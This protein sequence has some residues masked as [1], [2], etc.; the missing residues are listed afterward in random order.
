MNKN[1]AK[2]ENAYNVIF[3]NRSLGI[4]FGLLIANMHAL[5][6]SVLRIKI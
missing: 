2:N 5:V 4:L 1:R 3:E 6:I